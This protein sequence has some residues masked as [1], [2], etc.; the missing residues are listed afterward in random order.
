MKKIILSTLVVAITLS[1]T[2]LADGHTLS[3]DGSYVGGSSSSLAPDGSYV[4]GSSS[5]LAPDGTYVGN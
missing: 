4:G 5:S 2:A 1:T 3:P